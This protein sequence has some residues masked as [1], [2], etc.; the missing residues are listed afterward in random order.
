TRFGPYPWSTYTI[1]QGGDGGMEY[2]TATLITG[3]RNLRSLVGVIFHEAA[4]SWY[5]QLFG[6][7]ETVDEWFDEGF[8]SY[9]TELGMQHLFYK[10]GG[11][12]TNPTIDAYRSY[13]KLALSGKEEPMSLLAD[14]YNTTYGYRHEAYSKGAV[15]AEQ[16]GY[17]I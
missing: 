9:A 11:V 2:G 10:K 5:Q 17:I 6:I 13:Y 14:Y 7:N 15:M 3:N 16:L 8:T 1:A 12:E 4:H